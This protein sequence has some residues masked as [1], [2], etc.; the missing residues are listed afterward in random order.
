MPKFY[1]IS[2]LGTDNNQITFNDFKN[3][4]LYRIQSW[5]ATR[6]QVQ[7]FDIP[8]PESSG[9][10]DFNTY[11]GKEYLVIRG[12]MFP[13]NDYE[14]NRGR[15]IL[16]K[17]SSLTLEQ[18]DNLADNGYVQYQWTENVPKTLAVKVLYVDLPEVVNQGYIQ[19]FT[20]LC[21]IKYPVV[22]SQQLVSGLINLSTSGNAQAGA[23]IPAT[24]PTSIG[25]STSGGS[26]VP[27][28]LPVVLGSPAGAATSI[29][30]NNVGDF[31]TFPS[32]VINGPIAKPKIVNVTTG[33]Y[34]EFNLTLNSSS[35]NL[36]ITTDQDTLSITNN[37]VNCYGLM[38]AGSNIFRVQPGLTTFT[39]SGQSV[40]AGAQASVSF[41]SA[42]PLS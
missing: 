17:V 28:I 42:W 34:M 30:L 36:V 4:P 12:I 11:I 14:Y 41:F 23:L 20:I 39:L 19:Q 22:Y 29:T 26:T 8:L 21:K 31:E 7:E 18:N 38:T 24:V 3:S 9:V 15:E 5:F 10:N 32:I 6:R 40:G 33:E 37:G 16:R 25:S 35:D 13:A 27:F 1:D 2:T